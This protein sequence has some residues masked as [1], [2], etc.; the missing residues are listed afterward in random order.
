MYVS[1]TIWVMRNRESLKLEVDENHIE[2]CKHVVE[3]EENENDKTYNI[4]TLS[5]GTSTILEVDWRR[6]S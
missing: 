1:V 3:D 6:F 2:E 5:I 4:S